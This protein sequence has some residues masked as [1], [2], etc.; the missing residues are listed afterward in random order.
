MKKIKKA[1]DLEVGDFVWSVSGN[2]GRIRRLQHLTLVFVRYEAGGKDW[3][4]MDDEV[5][6]GEPKE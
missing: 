6:V 1:K 3:F 2:A 5:E 4:F